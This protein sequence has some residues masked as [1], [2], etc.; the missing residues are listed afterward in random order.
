MQAKP[1]GSNALNPAS[2][3]SR[4][5]CPVCHATQCPPTPEALQAGAAW[6]CARCGQHWDAW[7]LATR[8]AYAAWVGERG[9]L[10]SDRP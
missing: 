9:A 2:T 6:Q 10:R 1:L 5:W 4:A 8:A 3:D 7:R